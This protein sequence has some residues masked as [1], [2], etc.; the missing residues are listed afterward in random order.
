MIIRNAVAAGA[1]AVVTALGLATAVAGPAT[2]ATGTTCT[3]GL[4]VD[5]GGGLVLAG[6][7]GPG[8]GGDAPYT[9]QIENELGSNAPRTVVCQTGNRLTPEEFDNAIGMLSAI[10]F[11]GLLVMAQAS[12]LRAAGPDYF[13]GGQC[14][15]Q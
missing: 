15:R 6:G 12:K 1:A 14:V 9:L 8:Q 7:C 3:T 11:Y 5:V 13:G 2:A 10:P 4:V